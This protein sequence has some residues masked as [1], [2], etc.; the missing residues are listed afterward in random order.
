MTLSPDSPSHLI[1]VGKDQKA[2]QSLK[3]LRGKHYDIAEEFKA[4]V[5]EDKAQKLV[6]RIPAKDLFASRMYF[7]PF[8]LMMMFVFLQQIS[9]VSFIFSY[10]QEI[11][12]A[13]GSDLDPG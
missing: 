10:T 5:K 4:L 8:L 3:R 12:E 13:A 11:F 9:G 1:K 7:L 2:T 6:G